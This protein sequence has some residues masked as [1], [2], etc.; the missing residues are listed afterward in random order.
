M[1]RSPIKLLLEKLGK[2]FAVGLEQIIQHRLDPVGRGTERVGQHRLVGGLAIS[3]YGCLYGQQLIGLTC[4]ISPKQAGGR[5]SI[6]C[7]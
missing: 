4:E 3:M 5:G 2:V 6:A 1:E 7:G